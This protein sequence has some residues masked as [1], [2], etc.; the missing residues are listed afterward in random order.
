[1]ATKGYDFRIEKKD[2]GY[3][4][5]LYPNNNKHQPIGESAI[6]FPDEAQCRRGLLVFRQ[7]IAESKMEA[8]LNIEKVSD[9]KFYPCL[10]EKDVIFKRIIAYCYPEWEC[11]KW[12]TAIWDNIDA[13]LVD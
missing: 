13:P 6:V 11:K 10:K 7:I 2:E 9:T 4:F 5:R 3:V 1:M 12:A 8:L